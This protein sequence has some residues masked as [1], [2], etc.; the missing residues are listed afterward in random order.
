[1]DELLKHFW[2]QST[3]LVCGIWSAQDL[4]ST[5]AC[6]VWWALEWVWI[7]TCEYNRKWFYHRGGT[8]AS[9][10]CTF[11]YFLD[12]KQLPKPLSQVV[13]SDAGLMYFRASENSF[14]PA[15]HVNLF[16][17]SKAR[18]IYMVTKDSIPARPPV[19]RGS[20]WHPSTKNYIH[21]PAFN[22]QV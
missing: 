16:T 12:R 21:H 11:R 22:S 15:L 17:H 9:V 18:C 20:L 13:L 7:D 1:M 2:K 8:A 10:I 6:H 4:G 5:W 19:H 3:M 14:S